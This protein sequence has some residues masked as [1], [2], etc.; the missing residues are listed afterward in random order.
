[1]RYLLLGLVI[2]ATACTKQQE[3]CRMEPLNTDKIAVAVTPSENREYSFTD[4]KSGYYYGRTQENDFGEWFAGWNVRQKRIFSD[5]KLFVD[6]VFLDRRNAQAKMYPYKLERVF[7]Q[8]TEE[9]L[10]SDN[11]AV[12]YIRLTDIKGRYIGIQLNTGLLA[13]MKQGTDGLTYVPREA[14]GKEVKVVPFRPERIEY[15]DS[16][17]WTPAAAGGFLIAYG[18]AAGCDSLIRDFRSAGEL[19]LAARKERMEGILQRNPVRSNLDTLDEALA[20]LLLTT[21]ELVT[22]QQGKGIYAGLPWFNE[23]WGRDMFISMPGAVLVNGQFETAKEI[24]ADFSRFQNKD[25]V[26]QTWGRIPNRANT[27]GILYNTTDGTPR[28]VMQ[29]EDYIKY[30]GDTAFIRQIYP[31]V[32][33]SIDAAIR[34]YTDEKGYL[35]HADADTWMDVKR[36][37]IPGS[38]RG[39]RANDIQSLWYQ[40][41]MAG[42]YMA[43]YMHD[44]VKAGEWDSVAQRLKQNFEADYVDKGR[45]FIADHLNTDGSR[46]V[47]VRPNQLYVFELI[48]DEDVKMGVTRKVWEELVYPWGTGSLSQKDP[49][50]HPQHEN[51]EYYHKDDAYHNGTVWLWNNG[52]AMQR[53]IEMDQPD[54][55]WK[56]FENMNRQALAEGAVGSLS[57]NADAHPREG[58]NWAKRSGTFLQAWSNA[59]QLRVWYQYFLG[60]RPDMIK[61]EIVIEPKLPAAI[62]GLQFKERIGKGV[63]EGCFKRSGD[64][65]EYTYRLLN[66]AADIDFR[67]PLFGNV[68][69]GLQAGDRLTV[70]DSGSRL[71]V[72][73]ANVQGKEL[74]RYDYPLVPEKKRLKQL[75]DEFF[76]DTRFAVPEKQENLKALSKRYT[77]K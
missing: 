48:G 11:E 41:L 56:L 47:Q 29:I 15:T 57:E 40:Q 55:A 68:R 33:L 5:Y 7:A 8:A 10:M 60:I 69:V 65:T 38:P 26:S 53:M 20:W 22:D 27:E 1:M 23:Y 6:T 51:W 71:A 42:K 45:A 37:G 17:L 2:L 49:D 74:Y 30:S 16:V 50:F 32:A 35:L 9:L 52:H 72:V 54:I 46:D 61:G 70:K 12:L 64:V 24:L 43:G 36:N 39:N 4:K 18:T 77:G 21:D 62:T 58:K 25:S 19:K 67:L 14:P 34:N 3:E 73:V 31:A 76:K 44:R 13:S 75:R 59:E 66:E 28:F 63:L